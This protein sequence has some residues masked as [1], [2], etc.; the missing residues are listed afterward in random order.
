V[1]EADGGADFI[2]R[3][4][5]GSGLATV[6][7]I[8]LGQAKCEKF[9]SPTGGNHIARTVARLR[10]GWIGAYVTTSYFAEAVQREIIEDKYPIILI[11]GQRIAREVLSMM[12][13]QG[14]IGINSFLD[15]IDAQYDDMLSI[16]N[17]EE[18]LQD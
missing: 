14:E 15:S 11:N 10:R 5:I 3:L 1:L 6:K 16:R 2:G 9:D 4:D 18:I 8:V 13:E 17:A 12:H 7:V